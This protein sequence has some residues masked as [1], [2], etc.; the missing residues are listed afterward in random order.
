MAKSTGP[1]VPFLF[2]LTALPPLA[3]VSLTTAPQVP[4]AACS[5]STFVSW[6]APAGS[7]PTKS[8]AKE[9]QANSKPVFFLTPTAFRERSRE[10][11]V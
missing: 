1:V 7:E 10:I 3:V 8:T 4:T 2:Y 5:A 6:R 9:I 11:K